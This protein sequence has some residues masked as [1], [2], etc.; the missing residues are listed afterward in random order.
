MKI[1][2]QWDHPNSPALLCRFTGDWS[3]HECREAMQ[4]I[5]FM[6]SEDGQH[7]PIHCIYDLTAST[8]NPRA[9]LN[10]LQKLLNLS[11]HPA[12][13]SIVIVD[14]SYRVGTLEAMLSTITNTM[15]N[16][17]FEDSLNRARRIFQ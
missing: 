12:P 11:M 10:R 15:G 4:V 16:I 13:E 9:S 2:I 3:W 5:S 1:D 7:T 14:K 17:Y 6:Q 8:L